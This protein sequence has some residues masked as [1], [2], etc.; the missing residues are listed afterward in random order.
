MEGVIK[1]EKNDVLPQEGK[2]SSCHNDAADAN[3]EALKDSLEEC[4]T[5]LVQEAR[6]LYLS[7]EVPRLPHPPS[8][9]AF[10][11]DYVCPNQPV[12]I[13]NA[14]TDFPAYHRWT[15]PYL[16]QKLKDKAV[17]V[18]VTPDGYGD[19]VHD[20]FF[21][22]PEERDMTF[23]AFLDVMEGKSDVS[24]VFYVQK[25]N[26]NLTVD[27][28]ELVE[29]VKEDVPWATEAFGQK[30]DAV[31]FWMGGHDAVTSMHKDHYE[32]LYCVL[33]GSKTF[34]LHP[35]TDRPFIPY[36]TYPV[37]TYKEVDGQFRTI[38]DP[39]GARVPWIPV[40]PLNPDLVQWPEYG[41][42]EQIRCTV[43]RGEML[44]LP[45]LWFHHVSQEDKTIAVNYWYDMAYDIKY[46]YFT[47]LEKLTGCCAKW[48]K[49]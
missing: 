5:T 43:R 20:G 40:D 47:M 7:P 22:L 44:Y 2:A 30:P 49:R 25:Q 26:S 10:Y 16:R 41:R 45:S 31:N 23:P 21:V 36:E 24:G 3:A 13:E 48:M 38:P 14:F 17:T 37:A 27:L 1:A 33:Q 9:L 42:V 29:D 4:F 35:P 28:K 15:I 11:R 8:P 6:E 18:A 32:N 46:N 12:I 39:D 34:I 19:A